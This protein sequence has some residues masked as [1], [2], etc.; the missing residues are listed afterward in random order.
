VAFDV[1]GNATITVYG[2]SGGAT[3]RT[4]NFSDGGNIFNTF[5]VT[6]AI[7]KKTV[8]YTGSAT[9]IY[10]YSQGSGIN[11]Y[12][13]L[14]EEA[15]G[16]GSSGNYTSKE[17]TVGAVTSKLVEEL[18]PETEYTYQVKALRGSEESAY[19]APKTITTLSGTSFTQLTEQKAWNLIQT[20]SEIVVNGIAVREIALYN[21]TGKKIR[22]VNASGISTGNLERG[23]YIL[24]V[25]AGN[26]SVLTKK[27]IIQ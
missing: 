26:G 8:S 11:L 6:D 24:T 27:V 18:T 5:T 21:L 22:S 14:V 10:L 4:L 15:D 17:Y 3:E 16:G 2:I 7:A 20:K 9:T 1:T 13:I 19:S 12:A 23:C 25:H